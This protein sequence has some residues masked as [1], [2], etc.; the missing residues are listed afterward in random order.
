V[1]AIISIS[2]LCL[3]LALPSFA[4]GKDTIN[5][6]VMVSDDPVKEAPKYEALSLYIKGKSK[7]IEDIKLHIAR[8]YSEAAALF[9][10]GEAQGMF[11]GSFVGAVLMKKGMAKPVARPLLYDGTSTYRALVVA[12]AGTPAFTGLSDF[13]SPPGTRRKIVAYCALAS[14][15]EV[16]VRSLLPPGVKPE[17]RFS[18]YIC[19]SHGDALRAVADGVADYAVVKNQVWNSTG[20]PGLA[21]VGGDDRDNPNLTLILTSE[22]HDRY[23][24]DL[25]QVLL[26]LEKDAGEGAQR[27]KNTF[28]CKAFLPTTSGDFLHTYF[29]MERAHVD[30]KTFDFSF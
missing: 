1:K 17:D 27:V 19:A 20:Y 14:S 7:K 18:P 28:G 4:A 5:L 21:V 26:G 29:L 24:D 30:P 6:V 16:F 25:S 13:Q 3:L 23:G 10:K 12:R 2:F 11:A 9:S 22:A 8:D 15:G